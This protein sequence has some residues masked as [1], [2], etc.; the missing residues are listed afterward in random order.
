MRYLITLILIGL[1]IETFSF[2]G[3]F[4]V[5]ANYDFGFETKKLSVFNDEASSVYSHGGSFNTYFNYPLIPSQLELSF[6]LGLRYYQ[7]NA[8]LTNSNL[9]GEFVKPLLS[10][11]ALFYPN[12]KQNIGIQIQAENNVD[13]SYFRN[14]ESDLLRYSV[15]FNYGR[16]IAKNLEVF[17]SYKQG[18]YPMEDLY[19]IENPSKTVGLGLKYRII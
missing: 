17:I 14:E 5:S 7:L 12:K 3:H 4:D 13:L 1:Q 19:R 11:G 9:E 15:L 8:Q 10:L 6:G 16:V 2:N 18:F